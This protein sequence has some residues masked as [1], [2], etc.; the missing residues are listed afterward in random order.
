MGVPGKTMGCIFTPIPVE[1]TCYEAERIGV[2]HIQLG[3]HHQQRSVSL[4]SDL[5]QVRACCGR[6]HDMLL[7]VTH[8][9]DDVLAGKVPTENTTGR[10]L[11]ELVNRVP[12]LDAEAFEEMLNSNLKDLLMVLY[13]TNLTKAQLMLHEKLTLL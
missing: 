7:T 3:K 6:M 8:Y 9:I 10:F 4:A 11:L 12:K 1:V 2:D 5:Q 13:L